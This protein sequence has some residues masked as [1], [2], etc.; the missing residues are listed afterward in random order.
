[1]V[2]LLNV[3]HMQ[4]E[5]WINYWINYWLVMERGF[6]TVY[7]G[8]IAVKYWENWK[9]SYWV[10]LRRKLVLN[11]ENH[12]QICYQMMAG[13]ETIMMMTVIVCI[14]DIH[15]LLSYCHLYSL[16]NQERRQFFNDLQ[17]HSAV[18]NPSVPAGSL[19]V[20]H[21]LSIKRLNNNPSATENKFHKILST[22]NTTW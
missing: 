6:F 4:L 14:S 22:H 18:L 11:K 7:F 15:Y 9:L 20:H 10:F 8:I 2:H 19:Q 12:E 3:Y 16:L 13:L 5:Y 1:M 17:L 21:L